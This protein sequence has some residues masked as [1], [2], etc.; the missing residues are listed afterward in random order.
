VI[1]F[2]Y[3]VANLILPIVLYGRPPSPK[4][5]EEEE[6][7]IFLAPPLKFDSVDKK[8]KSGCSSLK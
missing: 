4:V 2:G 7:K 8:L 3:N 6:E 5:E 1:F